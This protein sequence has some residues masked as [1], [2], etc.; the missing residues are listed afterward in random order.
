MSLDDRRGPLSGVRVLDFTTLLPGPLATLMMASAGADVI[1]VERPGGDEMRGYNPKL[2]E[3]ST[4]FALLNRGKRCVVA[5]L[6]D[7]AQHARVRELAGAADVVIEQFRPGV[8]DRL[9]F[10]YEALRAENPGVVYCSITGYGREGP[11]AND[12][13]HDLNFMADAG[14]LDLVCGAGGEPTLPHVL[15]ADIAAGAYPAF[16]NVTLALLGRVASGEGARVEVSMT[17]ALFPLTYSSLGTGFR[18]GQ[19]PQPGASVVTGGSPRYRLYA[20]SDGQ[21]L[22]VAA[23]ENRFWERFCDL[24]GVG[25]EARHAAPPVAAA[26]VAER[27]GAESAAHW[28]TVLAGEDV[29]VSRVRSIAEAVEDPHFSHLF[30][31]HGVVRAGDESIPA[32]PIPLADVLTVP[33]AEDVPPL[34]P[35][36]GDVDWRARG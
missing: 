31:G 24:V 28:A 34:G 9:G 20:T 1:K 8:M 10:G 14:I 27:L 6:K 26:A 30:S 29:C 2:G 13:G 18:T 21:W 32:L 5:D 23:L 33:V 15:V 19:W 7:P 16:M 22:A 35:G 25:E 36:P 4:N 12:A 3:S 17:D 11:R